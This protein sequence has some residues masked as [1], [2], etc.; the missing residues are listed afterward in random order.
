MKTL[1]KLFLFF[2]IAGLIFSCSE[3]GQYM[4]EDFNGAQLKKGHAKEVMVT[5]PFKADFV[6]EY[7]WAGPHPDH[8]ECGVWDPAN[9]EFW[10]LVINAGEGT[11]TH[12]GHFTYKFEFCCNWASGVYPGP[13]EYGDGYF[14]A[15]NGDRLYIMSSG[16][17]IEGRLDDHPDYVTSW[18]RDPW[19]ITGGTG[20]FEDATGYGMTDDYNSELDPYSHHHWTGTITMIKGKNHPHH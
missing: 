15:A 7:L 3:K 17:V 5:V 9:G 6:G 11:A 20:R 12:M 8:P 19:V 4:D 13:G 16:Q 10:A 1:M 2:S 18:W 14:E